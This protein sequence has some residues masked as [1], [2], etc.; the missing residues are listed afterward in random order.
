MEPLVMD[1]TPDV[2]SIGWRCVELGWSFWWPPFALHPVLTPPLGN[3]V[4]CNVRGHIPYIDN[5]PSTT[6]SAMPAPIGPALK[7]SDTTIRESAPPSVGLQAAEAGMPSEEHPFLPED[8]VLTCLPCSDFQS[9]NNCRTC[10]AC[11]ASPAPAS[12]SCGP[13]G[14]EDN[15]HIAQTPALKPH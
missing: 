5:A 12:S 14:G 13:G 3:A 15:P 7:D 6:A 11:T 4:V 10:D 2:I 9:L 1:D 8:E